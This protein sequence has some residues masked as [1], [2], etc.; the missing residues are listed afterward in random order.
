VRTLTRRI[1]FM[2]GGIVLALVA[3]ETALRVLRLAPARGVGTVTATDFERLPGIFTPNQHVRD[4]QQPALPYTVTIDSLGFRG[5]D[6][7]RPKPASQLRVL[8]L[9]DSYVYG[10]FVDD[11]Q[12]FPFQLEERLRRACGDALV[13]NA[14]LGGTTIVDHAFML[15][16]AL[17]LQPD[18]VI[19]V[20]VAD[21][22]EN[23]VDS[24]SS[25]EYL[26]ENRLRK[27]RF[28]LS[29]V[30]PWARNTALWN[31]LVRARATRINRQN[32]QSLRQGDSRQHATT[33]S[34][35]RDRYGDALVGL[36]DTLKSRGV[37]FVFTMFPWA[38][39]LD[40]ASDDLRWMEHFAATHDINA[41]N[42]RSAL[43]AAR[44]PAEELY[45]MH[46]G[47]P[48]PLGYAIAADSL[49]ARVLRDSVARIR[50]QR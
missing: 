30:Y 9:G 19:G 44:R 49:A 10:D 18:L 12:T 11:N 13:I 22:F 17:P 15:Q 3:A 40:T 35:L 7:P 42:L 28:P 27:S 36:R 1:L 48:R 26:A 31:L 47:H 45:L 50:C 43:Q 16:R 8:M 46:D 38:T 39:D 32:E 33:T 6:F 34:R 4:L 2:A 21:D 41:V 37:A 23:L 24:K 5:A 25:W 20:Y 29:I 14:G